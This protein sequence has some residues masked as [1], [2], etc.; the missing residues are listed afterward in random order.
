M[1]GRRWLIAA[2]ALIMLAALLHLGVIIGGPPWYR[3]SGVGEAMARAAARGSTT[4]ALITLAIAAVLAVWAL[5]AFSEA[6]LLPRLP[7][8]RTGLLVIA[9]LYLLRAAVLV[10][11]V[12][13]KPA[14]ATP[15]WFGVRS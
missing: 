2:G 5:Y 7:L 14:M 6:G 3:F 4:P 8:L 1:A 13:F 15:S 10:S 11:T 12:L 9:A